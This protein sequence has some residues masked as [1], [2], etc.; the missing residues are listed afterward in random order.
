MDI[1]LHQ[2]VRTV[3][4]AFAGVWLLLVSLNPEFQRP[5]IEHLFLALLG[6]AFLVQ[7]YLIVK[8]LLISK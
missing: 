4:A 6:A 2:Q 1:R 8:Q 5:P 3:I 7:S